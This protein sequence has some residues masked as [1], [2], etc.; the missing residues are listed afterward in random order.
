VLQLI[1]A[2]E[3]D[4][5]RITHFDTRIHPV[6]ESLTLLATVALKAYL[7]EE[8]LTAQIEQLPDPGRRGAQSPPGQR[9]RRIGLFSGP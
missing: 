8:P 4:S 6:V 1:N 3:R 5:E 2:G 7:R 9:D